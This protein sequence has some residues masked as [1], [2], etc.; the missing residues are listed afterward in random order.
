MS[1]NGSSNGNGHKPHYINKLKKSAYKNIQKAA[2]Q[3]D[4]SPTKM[5]KL[6]GITKASAHQ[7][8]KKPEIQKIVL[9]EREKALKK[10]GIT[11]VRV[12]GK[13]N[14]NLDAKIPQLQTHAI[15]RSLELLGDI[16]N[17]D[18][19]N[20][21]AKNIFNFFIPTKEPIQE[22]IDAEIANEQ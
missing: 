7:H 8:L 20:E 1:S 21:G 13:I 9:D 11:R 3:A 19:A 17:K 18:K 6:L 15:D 2:I 14:K 10:V 5:G 16:N 22:L 12:Y 4:G